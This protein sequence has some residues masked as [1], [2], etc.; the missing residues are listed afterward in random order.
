MSRVESRPKRIIA[1]VLTTLALTTA[2]AEALDVR[3][4]D[5]KIVD[6]AKRFVV[7]STFNDD[8]VLDKETQLVWQRSPS[9]TLRTYREAVDR[10]LI[11]GGGGRGGWR[12]PS[13]TELR[14]LLQVSNLPPDHPFIVPHPPADPIFWSSTNVFDGVTL[15]IYGVQVGDFH[16]DETYEH[17]ALLPIWCVRGP[18][19]DGASY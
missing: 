9:P 3:S 7:L 4:W 14:S 15:R 17:S 19:A 16:P 11:Y 18:A 12:L 10:C 5:Q 1:A 8:A 6:P 2:S 13:A